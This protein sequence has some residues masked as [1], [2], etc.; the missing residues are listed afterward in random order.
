MFGSI[1]TASHP[2]RM[3]L[4]VGVRKRVV[5]EE[6]EEEE[7]RRRGGRKVTSGEWREKLCYEVALCRAE[8]HGY[9]QE[10]A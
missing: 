8:S 4:H 5:V 1:G 9:K 2:G 3:A 6:E 7:R 10:M